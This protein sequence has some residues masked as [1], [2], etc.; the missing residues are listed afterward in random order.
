[1]L[2]TP[3][4]TGSGVGI[5]VA[6]GVGVCVEVGD[7]AGTAD[8]GIGVPIDSRVGSGVDADSSVLEDGL[9]GDDPPPQAVRML[10]INAMDKMMDDIA[11]FI[12]L[13]LVV[14]TNRVLALIIIALLGQEH[15]ARGTSAALPIRPSRRVPEP[16]GSR[17][18]TDRSVMSSYG[19]SRGLEHEMPGAGTPGIALGYCLEG[20]SRSSVLLASTTVTVFVVAFS[21]ALTL[22]RMVITVWITLLLVFVRVP[23]LLVFLRVALSLL[24]GFGV[25]NGSLSVI[26]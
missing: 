5:G 14:K 20:Y 21:L 3:S 1:M 2:I 9:T 24:A 4:G 7:A 17:F 26:R 25:S 16:G 15:N 23:M 10:T 8:E 11:F 12:S 19:E 13:S 22:A 18:D 6:V